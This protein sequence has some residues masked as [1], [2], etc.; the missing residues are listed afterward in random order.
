VGGEPRESGGHDKASK[1]FV[2][3]LGD[4]DVVVSSEGVDADLQDRPSR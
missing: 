3:V 2:M 4:R 1:F